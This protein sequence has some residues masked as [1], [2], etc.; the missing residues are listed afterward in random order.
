[1]AVEYLQLVLIP[2]ILGIQFAEL[3]GE[4]DLFLAL[5]DLLVFQ[6]L[7][8]CVRFLMGRWTVEKLGNIHI[9]GTC[10]SYDQSYLG[11]SGTSHAGHNVQA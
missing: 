3:S 11:F 8:P 1:M 4:F 9:R 2:T 6:V 7:E 5:H 10:I